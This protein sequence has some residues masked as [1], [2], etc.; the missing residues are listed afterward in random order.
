V[1]AQRYRIGGGL[2]GAGRTDTNARRRETIHTMGGTQSSVHQVGKTRHDNIWQ[3]CTGSEHAHLIQGDPFRLT[4]CVVYGLGG[5]VHV[6]MGRSVVLHGIIT[7]RDA[8]EGED[9]FT[10]RCTAI[11]M[12]GPDMVLDFMIGN[13]FVG[14]ERTRRSN[15]DWLDPRKLCVGLL[16]GSWIQ[17][18]GCRRIWHETANT[19]KGQERDDATTH[20]CRRS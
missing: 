19:T 5:Q 4:Q 15:V 6:Q 12:Y 17:Y 13:W 7:V 8:I 2:E 9:L 20:S 11:G 3:C 1:L 18:H 10:N 14:Q 16:C